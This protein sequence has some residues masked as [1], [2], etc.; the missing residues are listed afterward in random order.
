[1][2]PAVAFFPVRSDA[3]AVKP[4]VF[5]PRAVV[6]TVD[7]GCEAFELRLHAH[8]L[9]HMEEDRP[10]NVLGQLALDLPHHLA[11]LVDVELHRL[12]TDQLVELG[13]AVAGVV[14]FSVAGEVLVEL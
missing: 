11:A 9:T 10:D 13:V 5:E 3:L 2:G 14:A 8:S 7:H 4:N 1:M 12:P 6:D